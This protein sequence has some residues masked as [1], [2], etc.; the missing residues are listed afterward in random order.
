MVLKHYLGVLYNLKK[1]LNLSISSKNNCV[2]VIN[3]HG[4][5]P[6]FFKNFEFQI[7]WLN[8]NYKIITP[9]E[10]KAYV[11]GDIEFSEH[12]ILITFDDGFISSYDSIQKVLN[13]LEIKILFFI[14]SIFLNH[15]N[16][17][18]EEIISKNFFSGRLNVEKFP[19][20]YRPIDNLKIK[21]LIK[22]GHMIGGH[23]HSHCDVTKINSNELIKKEIVQPINIYKKLF[24]IKLN[25]FAFPYGRINHINNYL[26][27]KI[28]LN[29]AYCFSNIRG[30][31][32]KETSNFAIKRQNV[33]PD[34]PIN[35]FGFI[36]EGGL[37]FYWKFHSNKL[38]L[39]AKNIFKK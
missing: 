5:E 11:N 31:N 1:Y 9:N 16:K 21:I 17:K 22:Q 14:P 37:D 33:S 29:Y 27:K 2:T 4:I 20:C 35:Y 7:N 28:T 26:L 24:D 6:E 32:S 12:C 38:N 25:S 19:D 3:Y 23:T 13:P 34:M 8:R 18:F 39:M 15:T 36:I 30:T 10:F